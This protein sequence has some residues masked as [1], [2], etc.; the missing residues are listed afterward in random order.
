MRRSCSATF[1]SAAARSRRK[2]RISDQKR[3]G[4]HT[5]TTRTVRGNREDRTSP[6]RSSPRNGTTS[7]SSRSAATAADLKLTSRT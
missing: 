1:T 5:N 7:R 6:P 2:R 3:K 4:I